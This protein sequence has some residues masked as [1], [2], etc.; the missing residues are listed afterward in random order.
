MIRVNKNFERIPGRLAG[1]GAN[2]KREALLKDGNQHTFSDHFYAGDPVREELRGIYNNKCA[3]CECKIDAGATLQV[4][5]YRPKKGLANDESHPGYYWLAYEW[6]N[7][8]LCCPICNRKKSNQFPVTGARVDEPQ[9]NRA[10]WRVDSES[11]SEEKPQLINPELDDP[12]EHL[13]FS[14][15]GEIRCKSGAAGLETINVCQ[16]DREPLIIDRKKM[17]D[18]FRSDIKNQ[19][20]ILIEQCKEGAFETKNGFQYELELCFKTIFKNLERSRNPDQEF[21]LLGWCMFNDFDGFFLDFLEMG[22]QRDI[23]SSA[24]TL[25]K[26][27]WRMP[28]D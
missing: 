11:L 18:R 9:A 12:A 23:V 25:Y 24:F 2:E 28:Q 6:S 7:L 21:S 22:E 3:Y 15:N 4:D 10:E 8:L 19:V 1:K 20:R 16:L 27:K 26:K 13:S 14:P 5:H 17:I